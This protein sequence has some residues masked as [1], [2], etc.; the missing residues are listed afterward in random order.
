MV[1]PETKLVNV[2]VSYGIDPY[3][4]NPEFTKKEISIMHQVILQSRNVRISNSAFDA[5]MVADGV[6]GAW[7]CQSSKIWDNVAQ[8]VI[9]EEAGGIY[10]DFYGKPIEYSNPLKRNGQ[11]YTFCA[12]APAIHQQLQKIIHAQQ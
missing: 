4:D 3:P 11:N 2:L 7:M 5:M 9:I 8:H 12:A 10:T 1:T 6:Y